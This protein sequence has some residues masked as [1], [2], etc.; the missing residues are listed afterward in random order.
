MSTSTATGAGQSTNETLR[1]VCFA[2]LVVNVAFIAAMA[3]QGMWLHDAQGRGNPTDFLNVWSAGKLAL[4]GHP[5]QAWDWDIQKT[6]QVRELGQDYIG[7]YAWH[8][9]PPF[10]FIATC[11]ATFSYGWAMAGWAGA[12]LVPY[13]IVVRGIVGRPLGWL[14]ALAFP[15]VAV[16]TLVGQNGFLTAALIGGTLLLLP[17]RPLLAGI[18]LG[19][20]SYKP[21]YGLLFPLALMLAA[22]WRA[23]A[24]AAVTVALMAV[25]SWLAF[26]TESW[27]AFFHWMPRFSQAFFSEG[28]ATWFKLQS[29]FGLVRY[30]GGSEQIAWMCQSMMTA[31]VVATVGLVWRSRIR[32][33]LKAAALATGALLIL[34]YLFLYDLMVLAIPVAF[35][36]QIGLAD[37][38]RRHE[39]P[40]LGVVAAL[41]LSFGFFEAPLGLAAILLVAGLIGARIV[42]PHRLRSSDHALDL[43]PT[44]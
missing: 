24:A 17:T 33:A 38:F 40:A 22:Q 11:L 35:L 37:G 44:R 12:S 8:Y 15:I 36:L 39:L 43:Q 7:N 27:L 9:P 34:P 23:F 32:Y 18:C 19:L 16:N 26:G 5:E 14:V 31:A 42:A 25:V 30:L 29:V 2:L 10:L 13:L 4:A 28:R 1:L 21:Q 3:M 41:L 20:L 6:L